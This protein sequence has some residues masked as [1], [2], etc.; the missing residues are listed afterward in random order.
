MEEKEQIWVFVDQL[1]HYLS[2]GWLHVLGHNGE[3]IKRGCG[4]WD[5]W[6]NDYRNYKYL[7]ERKKLTL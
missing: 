5:C 2:I 7:L 1:D 6:T 3:P 4:I